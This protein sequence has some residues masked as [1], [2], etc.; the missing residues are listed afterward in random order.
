MGPKP[1]IYRAR[2]LRAPEGAGYA[3]SSGDMLPA[4]LRPPPP[5]QPHPWDLLSPEEQAARGYFPGRLPSD[6]EARKMQLRS[7][8]RAARLRAA[9]RL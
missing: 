2:K 5:E 1:P 7:Q 6:P 9:G 8:R 3:A 4:S